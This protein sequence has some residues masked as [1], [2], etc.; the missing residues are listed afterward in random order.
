MLDAFSRFYAVILDHWEGSG[1]RVRWS[2]PH[3][4]WLRSRDDPAHNPRD[5][6]VDSPGESFGR[7]DGPS[8]ESRAA[9]AELALDF[10][11][12]RTRLCQRCW[13][14]DPGLHFIAPNVYGEPEVYCVQVPSYTMVDSAGG[15]GR[16]K[17]WGS[18]FG[19][20]SVAHAIDVGSGEYIGPLAAYVFGNPLP[21]EEVIAREWCSRCLR[22]AHDSGLTPHRKASPR[23]S[24]PACWERPAC[25]GSRMLWPITTASGK[26]YY[27]ER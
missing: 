21:A 7:P 2:R 17:H 19:C 23:R 3:K 1:R 16:H 14:F 15:T 5:C 20:Q 22:A 8:E 9:A 25:G 26:R 10:T 11:Q 4:A 27:G 24:W 6:W 12:Q 18:P 13:H